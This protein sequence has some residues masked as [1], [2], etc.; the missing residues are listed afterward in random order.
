MAKKATK[1]VDP[2]LQLAEMQRFEALKNA[3]KTIHAF[4]DCSC[5]PHQ[6]DEFEIVERYLIK[7]YKPKVLLKN[8]VKAILAEIKA[9]IPDG[10]FRSPKVSVKY[11][12]AKN[13]KVIKHKRCKK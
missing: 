9:E 1:K 8:R 6:M 5:S 2:A 12:P 10:G 13:G 4:A 7:M 3:F 11:I